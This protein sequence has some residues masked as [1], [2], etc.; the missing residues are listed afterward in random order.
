MIVLH[1]SQ[2]SIRICFIST[3]GTILSMVQFNRGRGCGLGKRVWQLHVRVP[4][5]S[6]TLS[7]KLT[8]VKTASKENGKPK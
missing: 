1:W 7:F 6:Y 2:N 5:N 3:P 4:R 8:A